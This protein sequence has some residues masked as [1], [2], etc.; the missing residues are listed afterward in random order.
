MIGYIYY[1]YR[2]Y[3]VLNG[4]FIQRDLIG[5][6]GGKNIFAFLENNVLNLFDRNGLVKIKNP[7]GYPP[8]GLPSDITCEALYEFIIELSNHIVERREA[9]LRDDNRLYNNPNA[10][11]RSQGGRGTW[12]GHQEAMKETQDRLDTALKHFSDHCGDFDLCLPQSVYDAVQLPIP[13]KPNW[14]QQ[15]ENTPS[16]NREGVIVGV[17][18]AGVVATGIIMAGASMTAPAWAPV[19]LAVGFFFFY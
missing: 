3:D 14:A 7:D 17:A 1:N 4:R 8:V 16:Q 5:E 12:R 19:A 9:M 2:H 13:T 11:P 18:V 10:K 6:L 15:H